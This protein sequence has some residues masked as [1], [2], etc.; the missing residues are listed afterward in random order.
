[1]NTNEVIANAGLESLGYEKG[2]YEHLHPIDD[3]NRSQS[4]N[5]VYPTAIKLAM[6]FGVQRLLERARE[7]HR[8][9]PREGPRVRPRAQGRTHP[10]AGRRADDARA[11]VR[12]LRDT[13]SHEDYD[14]LTEVDRRGSTRSTSV[15]RR[16]APGITADPRYAEAVRRHLEDVTGIPQETAPDLI[17]ATADAG[18]FMTLSGTLEARR[19]QALEDL[20]RPAPALERAAGGLRRDPPAAASG[21]ARRSCR[22]R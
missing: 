19:R 6:V 11:G 9:L 17:E 2:D 1:M 21:R 16:S 5:D 15:R 4:T 10:A 13:R 18:I 8:A 20:Q 14:R 7:A 12:R 22:A 3:V